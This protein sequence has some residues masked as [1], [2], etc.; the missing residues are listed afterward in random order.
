MS[1]TYSNTWHINYPGNVVPPNLFVEVVDDEGYLWEGMACTFDFS[2]KP[3][4]IMRYRFEENIHVEALKKLAG[5]SR[6]LTKQ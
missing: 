1:I 3:G 4:G 6:L 5:A 2:W